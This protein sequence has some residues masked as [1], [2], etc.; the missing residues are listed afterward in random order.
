[1]THIGKLGEK[2]DLPEPGLQQRTKDY[3]SLHLGGM[4]FLISRTNKCHS[5]QVARMIIEKGV[6]YF[7]DSFIKTCQVPQGSDAMFRGEIGRDC[8]ENLAEFHE[9]MEDWFK[10]LKAVYRV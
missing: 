2:Q 7:V 10:R 9:Y 5:D 6:P 1:M 8:A 3:L 4:V